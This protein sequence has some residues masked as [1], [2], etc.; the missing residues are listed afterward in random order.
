[1]KDGAALEQLMYQR[2]AGCGGSGS[3]AQLAV[4]RAHMGIDGDQADDEPFSDLR[5]G[6]PLS[7]ETQH[8]RLTLRQ[9]IRGGIFSREEGSSWVALV[10]L[11]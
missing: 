7:K 4:D 8:V 3:K 2:I 1:M 11:V 9:S 10:A 6:Q 5:A